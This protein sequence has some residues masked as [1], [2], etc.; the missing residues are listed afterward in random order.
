MEPVTL[1]LSA[2]ADGAAKAAGDTV[3][4]VYKALKELI[5]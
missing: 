1:I 5:K 3:P 2:L 4:D